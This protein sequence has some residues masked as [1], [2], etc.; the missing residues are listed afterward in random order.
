MFRKFKYLIPGRPSLLNDKASFEYKPAD[1]FETLLKKINHYFSLNPRET[2]YY[3][4]ELNYLNEIVANFKSYDK[5]LYSIIPYPFILNYDF[6]KSEVHK[7]EE[8]GMFFVFLDGKKLYYH[9]GYKCIEDVQKSFMYI[10]A[11]QDLESPHRYLDEYFYVNTN[12]VVADLGAAEG[13]FS[14]MIVDKVRELFIFEADQIWIE[15]LHKTFAPWKD[16]VH[17]VNKFVGDKQDESTVTLEDFFSDK[18][19]DAFKMDIE[20]ME[21]E[22]LESAR[23]FISSRNLR[24][25][26]TTYHRHSD[27]ANIK[28]LLEQYSYKTSFS[29]NYMLFIYDDLVPPY[30]RKAV[31][32]ATSNKCL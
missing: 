32:K 20:G 19:I 14:L 30:F 23:S 31:I 2:D 16:K 29:K 21:M 24:L 15:A 27:A 22:V 1:E 18:K 5:K 17:I 11:E 28:S 8:A 12:D 10:S 13:N 4:S 7:D 26:I 6:T 3:K 9:K 25:A